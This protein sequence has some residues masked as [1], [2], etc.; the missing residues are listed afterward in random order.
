[1]KSLVIQSR[2]FSKLTERGLGKKF[3]FQYV[4]SLNTSLTQK[5]KLKG[6]HAKTEL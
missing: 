3:L 4:N 5:Q 1:M 2:L 6:F